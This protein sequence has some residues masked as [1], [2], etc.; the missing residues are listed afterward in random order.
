MR[1]VRVLP[2]TSG[3]SYREWKG[4]FYPGDLPAGAMLAHYAERLPTVEINNTFYRL[5]GREAVAR[6]AAQ[7][8]EGFV[9]AITANQ[10]ITHKAR[11]G[12]GALETLGYLHE[13]LEALGP[14]RGPILAQLPPWFRKD[15]ER[16]H[17]FLQGAPVGLR[18]AFEFR[19]ES[20]DD[21]DVRGLLAEHDAAWC[22]VDTG[23]DDDQPAAVHATA[24]W[25][26]L[27][28]RRAGY[29]ERELAAWAERIAAQPWEEAF[30]YFKHEDEGIAPRLALRLGELLRSA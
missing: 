16:L 29:A 10:R 21:D 6:W 9:F 26:Y 24:S 18:L 15:E 23:E 30:V 8:P 2:G 22:V 1:P 27:R 19:H 20:W 28:L 17:T 25:G 4:T 7:V 11:L 12:D 3:F 14:H 13:T 5:P